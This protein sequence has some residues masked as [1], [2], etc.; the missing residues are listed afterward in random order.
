V[1]AQLQLMTV[2]QGVLSGDELLLY[3]GN[4]D[5]E[6]HEQDEWCCPCAH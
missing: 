5:T 4:Y 2:K 6:E 3:Y 1:S